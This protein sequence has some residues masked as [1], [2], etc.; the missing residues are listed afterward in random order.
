MLTPAPTGLRLGAWMRPLR[1][2]SAITP[3]MLVAV[4]LAV[5]DSP[6]ERP[7]PDAVTVAAP[8]AAPLPSVKSYTIPEDFEADQMRVF[9]EPGDLAQTNGQVTFVVRKKD[10]WLVDFWHNQPARATGGQLGGHTHID[11]LWQ[12]HAVLHDGKN[13]VDVT[14]SKVQIRGDSIETSTT[15]SLGAGRMRVTTSYRLEP[16]QPRIIITTKFDHISGGRLTHLNLGDAVKWGNTDYFVDGKRQ[17]ATFN[18]KGKWVGRQGAS[19][20][21]KLTTLEGKPMLVG[22]RSYHNG[23]SGEIRTAYRNVAL[24]PGESVLVQRALKYDAIALDTPA[25]KAKPGLL[26]LTVRDGAGKPLAA[27]LSVQGLGLTKSPDFGNTGGL[28]GAGRFVWSGTGDFQRSLPPGKYQVWATAGYE[29]EAQNWKVEIKSG[30]TLELKGELPRAYSTPGWL[31]ADLHLHQAPSPDSDIGCNTRVISVAAEGVELAA[32]TD[33]YA[34]ADLG[35]SVAYLRQEGL[36]ATP[37]ATMVGS[38]VSTVGNLFGHF[39]LFPMQAGDLVEYR[40]TTPKRMF[41]EMRKV[42]PKGLIQVNHPRMDQIGYWA[43]YKVDPTSMQVPLKYQSEYSDDYDLLEVFNGLEMMSEPKLRKVLFDW[44][45]LLGRGYRY[46]GT[47]NSDSH[48]LF[49]L[50]PGLP[51]NFIR[52]PSSKSDATDLTVPETEIVESLRKGRVTVSSGP[53]LEVD[54]NGKGPGETAQVVDGKVPLH[55]RISAASW[56]SVD[57]VELLLGGNGRRVRWLTV[58]EKKAPVRFDQTIQLDVPSK[59]FVVVLVKGTKA[60][61][62]TF[63]PNIKPFAFSNPIWLEP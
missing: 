55:I 21:M 27:K 63:T 36:L 8:S 29:R 22:F 44:I 15:L 1:W 23:L 4:L 19:G 40:D 3:P 45:K 58:K 13:Q 5:P 35:P 54:V 26:K 30:E 24:N 57:S 9:A 18:G 6:A 41:A 31:S 43:R 50:D 51:R 33:H 60:L 16:D 28:D 49:F 59:T 39:N 20:D 62:N 38:E 42:A 14:A 56:I 7:T 47:G 10:G 53:M 34:V 52:V 11:G 17:K 46:T 61:P 32:A 2:V 25:P 12:L 48:N 37:V